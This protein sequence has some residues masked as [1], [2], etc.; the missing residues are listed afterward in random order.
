MPLRSSGQWP[1][2][3]LRLGWEG[4]APAS[5]DWRVRCP[6]AGRK[7]PCGSLTRP[8][9]AA[10]TALPS[11]GLAQ[12]C[13][14]GQLG[15]SGR[16]MRAHAVHT[17]LPWAAVTKLL[18]KHAERARHKARAP[19]SYQQALERHQPC[20]DDAPPSALRTRRARSHAETEME[21][22]K[23]AAEKA[24]ATE[25]G[26]ARPGSTGPPGGREFTPLKRV[27][28]PRSGQVPDRG[29]GQQAGDHRPATL[30]PLPCSW[31]LK[32]QDTAPS[33]S[34][35][36]HGIQSDPCKAGLKSPRLASAPGLNVH[37]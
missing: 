36:L 9:P 13:S 18:Q 29:R 26:W 8:R 21:E 6:G 12:A 5:R 24:R 15:I 17:P 2:T 33:N 19:A 34:S 30:G 11:S 1:S 27:R 35:A 23:A 28:R 31:A 14:N 22:R 37:L 4:Q 16:V 20:V 10:R 32:P 7:W 3:P 25:A